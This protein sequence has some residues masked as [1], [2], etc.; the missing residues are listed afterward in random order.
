MRKRSRTSQALLA[1]V[2]VA[3]APLATHGGQSECSNVSTSLA[4]T[5]QAPVAGDEAFFRL[6]TGP[7]N[8]ML[9]L[10]NSGSMGNFPQCGDWSW[11]QIDRF[12]RP[13]APEECQ[14]P[15]IATPSAPNP[16]TAMAAVNGTCTPSQ[17]PYSDDSLAWMEAVTPTRSL[18]DPGHTANSL[19][20]DAPTWGTGCTGN[21]C[22]FDPDA[23]Y[24]YADWSATSSSTRATRR[25]SDTDSSL[26]GGCRALD[27]SGNVVRDAD[28]N[29]VDLGAAC[30]TCMTNHG[31]F[32]YNATYVTSYSTNNG[33][34]SLRSSASVSGLLFKGTF[35]NANPPKFVTAR[36][37]LK[38]LAW[39]DPANANNRMDQ[40]R[41]GL[42]VLD[43]SNQGGKLI[44]PLGPNS[45]NAF[46]PTQANF[47][48]ARQAIIDAVNTKKADGSSA[49]GAY[50]PTDSCTPLGSALFNVG[51]Y[52]S[53]A[54]FYNQTFSGNG[55]YTS[56]T[57][58]ASWERTSFVETAAGTIG[59]SWAAS[60][61]CSICW[62]CQTNSVIV[63][64]DGSPNTEISFPSSGTNAIT[65]YA[66]STY[67]LGQNCGT[68]PRFCYPP[69]T[70][71][72]AVIPRVAAWLHEH[73]LRSDSVMG[74]RQALT[75]HT[76]AFNVT[77]PG[78]QAIVRATANM[79][80]G[81]Y[82]NAT[83]SS[84]LVD[85]VWN[86]VNTILSR[87]DSFSAASASS[88]Q[89]VQTAAAE[90]FLT[91]F[92]P[93]NTAAWEGHLF[94]AALFDEFLNG[95]DPTKPFDRQ[96]SVQCAGKSVSANFNN[97]QDSAGNAVCSGVFL[98]DQDCDE[99]AE[100]STTGN[101]VK[102]G[103]STAAN[104]PWDGGA[105]LSDASKAG[106]TSAD[107]SATGARNIFTY[108][109]GTKV[110][111]TVANVAT[112]KPLLAIDSAWC[113]RLLTQLG[114]PG[115]TD[116]TTM[117]AKQVIYFARGWD[118]TNIDGDA[119]WGPENPANASTCPAGTSGEQRD[120]A[121]DS[122]TTKTFWKLGDV[123]HSSP[124]VVSPP[125]DEFR[126]DT[127]FEKQCVMTLHSPMGLPNQ[128]T[129]KNDYT[130]LTA[131][132]QVDAYDRYRLDKR[133]RKRVVLVGANDGMLHAFDAGDAD[134]SQAADPLG[135]YPYSLGNGKEL[136]AFVPPDLLPRLKD[137]LLGHQY[138]VDGSVMVRDVW[139]DG[140]A[141]G[142]GTQD[143]IKQKDEFHTVA[144]FGERS[145]GTQYSAL[146]VTDPVNPVL[147]WTFP[148]PLSDDARFMGESWS[149][150][151]PRPPP[152]GPV[153]IDNG[154]ADARG[155]DE[156][157]IVMINGGYDPAMLQG[158]AVF[159]LDAWTGATLW[160]FTD[161]D[162]KTQLGYTTAGGPTSMF[163]VPAGIGLSDI[164]DL[165]QPVLDSDGFFDTATW[166]DLGGNLFVARFQQPGTIA[167]STGR[168]SNWFAARTFEEGRRTDDAQYATNRSEFFYMTANTYD[169]G[170]HVLRTFLGS[171]NR[172]RIMQQTAAC[173]PDNLFSC[174]QAGCTSVTTSQTTSFGACAYSNSFACTSGQLLRPATTSTGTCDSS[175]CTA[176][177]GN[178][179]TS[180]LTHHLACPGATA[181]PDF[182]ASIG[183]D[184]AGTCP[185][186]TQVGA[187]HDVTGATF[188][189]PPRSRF[190][191]VWAYGRDSH[192][193]FTDQASAR[194]FDANRF[195][196][197][198]S[199]T[200]TC[201]GPTG[202]TC[203]LVD[204]TRA[205][206]TFN[207]T[208][209]SLSSVACPTGV[210]T[211]SATGDD[212]GWFYEYGNICP[213][214]TCPQN[215]PWNDEKTGSGA[216]VVLGC[217]TWGSFRPVGATTSS[218]PCSGNVGTPLTY[219]MVADSVM[220]VPTAACGYA[221]PNGILYRA[222]P[223]STIAPPSAATVR[224]TFNPQ[225]QIAYSALQIDAG[226][227]PTNKQLGTRS[228]LAESIYWLEVPRELHACR[229]VS[230]ASCE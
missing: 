11:D 7:A 24:Q 92:R 135:V 182:T 131:G 37:V 62:A 3:M 69:G 38:D 29:P 168:V 222:S 160:R 80:G 14:S 141:S 197:V 217:A 58:S 129:I 220:G 30:R 5:I 149:D 1:V 77:D 73:D 223:R 193:Q 189:T 229:H 43:C 162:F 188:G 140:G 19:L 96:P 71:T 151:A 148:G 59:A 224:V 68:S 121:N 48:V 152:I 154:G 2:L 169:V 115:G 157:W 100:D 146:D 106:Y 99:I 173:S 175:V 142:T 22:L 195:T 159:M 133:T 49:S 123:F 104:F 72:A 120:R 183:C 90:A 165:N 144:I 138:M 206:V 17:S 53:S 210:T 32:F 93:N 214:K 190:Y 108:V 178:A 94:R 176:S 36:K 192:K 78:A 41:L 156:R 203:K 51:Q 18:P 56:G 199:Y 97:D 226:A 6:P 181:A 213:A 137:T 75:I 44:V 125:I 228:S 136:W 128:T 67:N 114:I 20:N 118:V 101:F 66:T 212:A 83:T 127:G 107:E 185:T 81:T 54:G 163:P 10:D 179:F 65:T 28:N 139:V 87:A 46:P 184:A 64:T 171:G 112:L 34:K 126:C 52:F 79:G 45:T 42:T 40:V 205:T 208:N 204:V 82:A 26:V 74:G 111:L 13:V 218:D 147:K 117:C 102:K 130:G 16:N 95:C 164:G 55:P 198:S 63:I 219:G 215:P 230:A 145:G 57:N 155:F 150:F 211:C 180:S 105:V 221:D 158:R 50:D 172:E 166:G 61:Q 191:G 153:K 174:C 39:M 227:P 167:A 98:I 8:L 225:G 194:L 170:K 124:A 116:P 12:G 122:A 207:S 200:G 60:N 202:S 119:C 9:L 209:P 161:D 216:T 132:T 109:A 35:L 89:T 186:L 84:S 196:D 47:A 15:D 23:Y 143:R 27:G 134:T 110:A 85:A 187:G 4:S 70:T 25:L 33:S 21:N 91:R 113:T 86:A 31:F 88:L 177:P 201:T 76:V 103:T